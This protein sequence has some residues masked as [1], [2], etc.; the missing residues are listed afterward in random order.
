[1]E[2]VSVFCDVLC[3]SDLFRVF[4]V[5]LLDSFVI[6]CSRVLTQAPR[7]VGLIEG[8]TEKA[9]W[10][11]LVHIALRGDS[12]QQ[13]VLANSMAEKFS[14][15]EASDLATITYVDALRRCKGFFLNVAHK[16]MSPQLVNFLDRTLNYL[17]PG[18]VLGI[19]VLFDILDAGKLQDV[20][21]RFKFVTTYLF[22]RSLIFWA[23]FPL[24]VCFIL[25]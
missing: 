11:D 17:T 1:M 19:R 24:P 20:S 9:L 13:E 2:F 15:L 18:V 7:L 10:I 25:S 22:V 14:H 12:K 4:F 23:C 16:T 8:W 5:S 21:N 6:L 3:F